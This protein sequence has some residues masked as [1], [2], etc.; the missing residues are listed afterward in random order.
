MEVNEEEKPQVRDG[1]C[2]VNEATG[3]A[4]IENR[5]VMSFIERT[6]VV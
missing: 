2:G 5:V 4:T 3:E 1:C 6:I